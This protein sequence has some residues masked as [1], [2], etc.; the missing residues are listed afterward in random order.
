MCIPGEVGVE[1][2]VL[3][4]NFGYMKSLTKNDPR[5]SS[6]SAET[7]IRRSDSRAGTVLAGGMTTSS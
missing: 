2:T 6:S 4:L 1:L 7:G 3:F 5:A